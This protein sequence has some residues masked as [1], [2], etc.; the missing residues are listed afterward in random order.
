MNLRSVDLN[1]LVVLDALLTERNVSRAGRR[2]GLSQ[3]AVSAAL[4]RLRALFGDPLLVRAGRGLV[5][6]RGAEDL[7]GPVREILAHIEQTLVERPRF[8]P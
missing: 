1:L 6:T 5:L 8:D 7:I 3:P 2:I 4:G